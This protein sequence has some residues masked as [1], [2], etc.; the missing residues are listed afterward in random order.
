M[1]G[2]PPPC[3]LQSRH[4]PAT[5]LPLHFIAWPFCSPSS[6]FQLPCVLLSP[7]HLS[8]HPRGTPFPF[9]HFR[10]TPHARCSSSP[11]SPLLLLQS[12]HLMTSPSSPYGIVPCHKSTSTLPLWLCMVIPTPNPLKPRALCLLYPSTTPITHPSLHAGLH[13]YSS[14]HSTNPDGSARGPPCPKGAELAGP[15]SIPRKQLLR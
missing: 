3:H 10:L 4:S 11:K 14:G 12:H 5:Y 8:T 1:W 15:F 7:R 9:S 2:L 6:S 13:V